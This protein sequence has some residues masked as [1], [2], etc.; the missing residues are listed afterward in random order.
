MAAQVNR[1]LHAEILVHRDPEGYRIGGSELVIGY[2]LCVEIV[3]AL[4]LSGIS[5]VCKTLS[6]RFEGVYNAVAQISGE[7]A[8]LGGRII[9]KL[10]GFGADLNNL[11]LLDN[12]HT[13]SVGNRYARTV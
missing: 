6:Y 12:Y 8:R 2:F 3:N 7:Y 4:I 10:A 13:L 11:A 1:H 9:C 5:A